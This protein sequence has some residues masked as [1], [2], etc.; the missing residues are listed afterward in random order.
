MSLRY[1]CNRISSKCQPNWNERAIANKKEEKDG[2]SCTCRSRCLQHRED[3]CLN[4]K[5]FNC[6]IFHLQYELGRLFDRT[7]KRARCTATPVKQRRLNRKLRDNY[8]YFILLIYPFKFILCRRISATQARERGCERDGDVPDDYY[9][10]R[11]RNNN[12]VCIYY[13]KLYIHSFAYWNEIAK[14]K[15]RMPLFWYVICLIGTFYRVRTIH[16]W[17]SIRRCSQWKTFLMSLY[18]NVALFSLIFSS[19]VCFSSA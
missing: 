7:C 3:S 6:S 9:C 4:A 15:M 8:T 18:T 17:Q 2:K 19:S 16:A 12:Y 10:S 13:T 1:N 14:L 5:P 11:Q